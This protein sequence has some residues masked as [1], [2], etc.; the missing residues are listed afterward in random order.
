MRRQGA[1]VGDQKST[2]TGTAESMT[3]RW[4][5]PSVSSCTIASS[6]ARTE[7]RLYL[8]RREGG[9]RGESDF[10]GPGS[11]AAFGGPRRPSPAI[12]P[13]LDQCSFRG[14]RWL[15]SCQPPSPLLDP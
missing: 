14:A 7:I 12:F 10:S 2:K 9:R 8:K 11:A 13:R 15:G 6:S 5:L 1:H 4:K 3:S